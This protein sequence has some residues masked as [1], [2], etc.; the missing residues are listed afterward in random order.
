MAQQHSCG[1]CSPTSAAPA[2]G[3]TTPETTEATCYCPIDGVLGTV[4]KKYA[5]RIVAILGAAG[6]T[7][8]GELQDRLKS[9]SSA[10]LSSHLDELADAKLIERRSF[11]EVPPRVEYSLTPRGRELETRLQPLLEWASDETG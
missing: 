9:A 8:Y 6:P 10:T 4:S 11:D 7:R 2:A 1:C 3:A 5:M